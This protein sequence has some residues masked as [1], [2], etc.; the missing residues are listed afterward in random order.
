MN[1]PNSPYNPFYIQPGTLALKKNAR[2]EGLETAWDL[3]AAQ[4]PA[5]A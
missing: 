3:F 5:S 1:N 2:Q 4:Q